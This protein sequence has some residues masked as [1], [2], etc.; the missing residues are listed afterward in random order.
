MK[1]SKSDRPFSLSCLSVSLLLLITTLPVFPQDD[2]V[3]TEAPEASAKLSPTTI[4][5]SVIGLFRSSL[6]GYQ[7]SI[8]PLGE[9]VVFRLG[10]KG[11]ATKFKIAAEDWTDTIRTVEK[12]GFWEMKSEYGISMPSI[13]ITVV[14]IHSGINAKT[15]R[16]EDITLEKSDESRKQI[17]SLRRIVAELRRFIP[18]EDL[19][20]PPF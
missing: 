6:R 12:A 16:V 13:P 5:I 20:A 2:A 15:I 14:T 8:N 10:D 19:V 1:S 11:K 9:G 18:V 17:E 4:S 7:A 3:D